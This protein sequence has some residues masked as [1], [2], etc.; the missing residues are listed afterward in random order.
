M[1]LEQNNKQDGTP[2]VSS[3]AWLGQWDCKTPGFDSV[4]VIENNEA[5]VRF[6]TRWGTVTRSRRGFMKNYRPNH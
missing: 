3:T 4:E 6:K 1:E 5:W 2:A